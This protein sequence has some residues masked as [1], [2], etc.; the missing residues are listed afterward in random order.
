[1]IC[2]KQP[3]VIFARPHEAHELHSHNYVNVYNSRQVLY[4][5]ALYISISIALPGSH[6]MSLSK[7][8]PIAATD[9]VSK[10][11]RRSATGNCK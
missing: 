6:G 1:M 3:K 9:S 11:T 10:F 8:L 2:C 4:C 5:I 7:A